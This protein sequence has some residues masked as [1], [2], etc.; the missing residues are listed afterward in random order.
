ML[1]LLIFIL[2]AALTGALGTL[3]LIQHRNLA[4][5]RD[6]CELKQN[7]ADYYRSQLRDRIAVHQKLSK[8]VDATLEGV[9]VIL[10]RCEELEAQNDKLRQGSAIGEVKK[11][12]KVNEDMTHEFTKL[13]QLNHTLKERIE[14]LECEN[15]TIEKFNLEKFELR[16]ENIRLS[17]TNRKLAE[18]N[19][20]LE[21][22]INLESISMIEDYQQRNKLFSAIDDVRRSLSRILEPA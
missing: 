17:M 1:S 13:L 7:S 4:I 20:D 10:R 21:Y 22:A 2:G 9:R 6:L 18:R 14:A 15:Q 5:L 12:R 19:N 11:L 8:E 16:Q 3:L